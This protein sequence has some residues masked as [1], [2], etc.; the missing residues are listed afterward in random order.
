MKH[1][2][3]HSSFALAFFVATALR[4]DQPTASPAFWKWAPTP[5]MGW[6]SYDALGTSINEEELLA[7]ARYMRDHLRSHGWQYVVIDARWYDEVS[8]FNDRD[9]N[10]ERAGAK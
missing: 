6:N 9:F 10:K 2:L 3:K 5:P 7:N 4:A 1:V 8:S